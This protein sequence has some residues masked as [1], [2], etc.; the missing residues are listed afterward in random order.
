M[1]AVGTLFG[2]CQ[3]Y[4]ED[5]LRIKLTLL[6]PW[7]LILPNCPRRLASVCLCRSLA[8]RFAYICLPFPVIGLGWP[9]NV[10]PLMGQ[11]DL[12]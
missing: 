1:R 12:A 2:S 9:S 4:R 10:V 11:K 7:G 6:S 3:E 5:E 8:L